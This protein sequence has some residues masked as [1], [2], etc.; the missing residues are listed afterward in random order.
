[1]KP[2]TYLLEQ[3]LGMNYY[4]TNIQGI[5]GV[6]RSI[7]QDF[8]V[9]ELPVKFTGTGPYLI[10]K[11]TK[12]AWEHQHA[13]REITKRLGISQ[14]RIGWGGNK[15]RN[16]VTTQY[17]SLYKITK[18]ELE[19]ITIKDIILKPITYH[20]FNLNLGD[21][22]GNQFE[23]TL[24]NCEPEKLSE[25]I[26]A[27]TSDILSLGIPNYYGI[28]RFGALKP[29]THRIGLHILRGEYES[30]IK[31]YVG[32][33]FP[34]ESEE[35]KSARTAFVET[36]NAKDALHD[37]PTRL[38]YERI[39]LDTLAKHPGEYGWALQ[40]M[41][42]KLLSMFVSAYQSWLFNMSLSGRCAAGIALSDVNVGE[43][44]IFSNERIDTVTK[45]NLPIARQHIKHGRCAVAAWMPGSTLPVKPGPLEEEMFILMEKDGV[46]MQSFENAS[47]FTGTNFEGNHRKIVL[48]TDIISKIS[49]T[50]V[51]LRFVL[52]PG[53]YATT[54]CRE[55]MQ[56]P[57]EQMI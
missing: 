25:R 22:K 32:T 19:K 45:R 28:Q 6:L 40:A 38:T 9:E 37:L 24:R 51:T 52:P 57:P 21:L 18:T 39:M 43:H 14:K 3:T 41:P 13:M 8:I 17:I 53:H 36:G 30:A 35:I 55:Y 2:S 50:N 27:I 42:P 4:A 5:G 44:L 23:I 16:A 7:P 47:A 12:R 10:V 11:L 29:I 54:V 1:M 33:A 46:S 49:G 56:G 34:Q 48:Q 31:A 15:D 20:Q 26:T